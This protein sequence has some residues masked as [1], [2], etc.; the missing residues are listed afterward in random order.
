MNTPHANT[1][2]K[3]PDIQTSHLTKTYQ[4]AG[5]DVRALDDVTVTIQ[6]GSFCIFHGPSGSGKSTLLQLLGALDHPTEGTLTVGNQR[7]DNLP[8]HERTLYRREQ[9]GFIFQAF[10]LIEN[11]TALQNVLVPYIPEGR[12]QE[13][14]ERAREILMEVGLEG[15]LDHRPGRLSGGEQQ[16][17]A[18]ARAIL[19]QPRLILA[20]EPTGELDTDT[21][22]RIFDL[23]RKLND[24]KHTTVVVVTHD[25]E[26]IQNHDRSVELKDGRCLES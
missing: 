11:L 18:I 8:S 4:V 25:T 10:N 15:R 20:D 12:D 26:F 9:V 13:M 5:R 19:K 24:Q 22:T 6:G 14:H 7:I 21:G 2:S 1:Q 16:R 17:V 23:L 3:G